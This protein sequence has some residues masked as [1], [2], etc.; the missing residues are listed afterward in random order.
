MFSVGDIVT[1]ISIPAALGFVAY[2][3]LR[4]LVGQGGWEIITRCWR[5]VWSYL[6][7]PEVAEVSTVS[8][9]DYEEEDTD[10][11][12]DEQT[13]RVFALLD[14]FEQKQLDRTRALIIDSAVSS[15][16][17]VAQVRA[18]IKGDTGA[19]GAEIAEARKRLGIDEPGRILTIRQA[20]EIHEVR[21]EG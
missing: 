17:G 10:G 12:T 15:G 1:L 6:E 16:W 4:A 20:G 11:Q 21:M 7:T 14:A 9:D 19:I 13:D 2:A 8:A 5:F 18:L 3:V